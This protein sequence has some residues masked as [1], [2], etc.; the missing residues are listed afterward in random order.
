MA[1]RVFFSF[2]FERDAWRAGQ[3]RNSW[4][5][6]K[7]AEDAGFVDAAEWEK[8]KKKGTKAITDWI[9]SQLK[10]TSVTVVLIGNETSEREYIDYEIKQ[11]HINNK[12]MLGIYIHQLKN[13]DGKTD[14][15]GTNPFSKFYIEENGKKKY[16]NEIY[17]TY[18]WVN[19]NGYQN[20]GSWI[21]TAAKNAGR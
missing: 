11:S 10:G 8:V 17:T 12:G 15:K 18:D 14:S 4:V 9:D 1:R 5:T 6:K 19:D 16:L 20:L 21:E 3:V 13:T 7:D 2:H